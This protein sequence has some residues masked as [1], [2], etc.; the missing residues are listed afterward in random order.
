MKINKEK[1]LTQKGKGGWKRKGIP[2]GE[3]GP[4]VSKKEG[5]KKRK[6]A[7]FVCLQGGEVSRQNGSVWVGGLQLCSRLEEGN[8]SFPLYF[9]RAVEVGRSAVLTPS[10][11]HPK[12]PARARAPCRALREAESLSD[13]PQKAYA[14][15][16]PSTGTQG[17]GCRQ[18]LS[19]P[20]EH[21][22]TVALLC[23]PP[24]QKMT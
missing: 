15:S 2:K 7:K 12:F 8:G 3:S 19:A 18:L 14:P 22:Y 5:G 21:R 4:C 1:S 17:R 20:G 23:N 6:V 16:P 11:G 13:L 24:A 10:N 9:H